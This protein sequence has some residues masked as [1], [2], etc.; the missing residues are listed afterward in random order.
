MTLEL[1]EETLEALGHSRMDD[2]DVAAHAEWVR[3]SDLRRRR[4]LR[5][6][7]KKL[8]TPEERAAAERKRYAEDAEFRKKHRVCVD[9]WNSRNKEKMS[10]KRRERFARNPEL[11]KKDS[12]RVLARYYRL[13]AERKAG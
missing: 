6:P 9:S 7:N 3:I 10:Q 11:R 2:Y 4:V 12:A 8:K 13:K 5:D 1:D